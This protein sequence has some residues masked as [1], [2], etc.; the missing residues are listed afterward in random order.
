MTEVPSERKSSPEFRPAGPVDEP[1]RV[2]A[3][4][5]LRGFALLGIL[6]VNIVGMGMYGGAYDDPMAAGGSTG[7]TLQSGL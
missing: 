7:P 2:S 5:T 4:D 1:H 3:L 6:L